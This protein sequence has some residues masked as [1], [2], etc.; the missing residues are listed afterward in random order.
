MVDTLTNLNTVKTSKRNFGTSRGLLARKLAQ[1]KRHF[2]TLARHT[3]RRLQLRCLIK[4]SSKKQIKSAT[5]RNLCIVS[6]SN[7]SRRRKYATTVFMC[8]IV[9]FG[10]Y[11]VWEYKHNQNSIFQT[12]DSPHTVSIPSPDSQQTISSQFRIHACYNQKSILQQLQETHTDTY[13]QL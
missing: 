1:P 12:S 10:F 7:H 8:C 4:R 2:A 3:C 13:C 9:L 5:L 11:S 6:I